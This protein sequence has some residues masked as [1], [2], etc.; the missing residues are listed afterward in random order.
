[1]W[2]QLRG[3]RLYDDTFE[4]SKTRTIDSFDKAQFYIN[5]EQEIL[6]NMVRIYKLLLDRYDVTKRDL[7]IYETLNNKYGYEPAREKQI[8]D[9]VEKLVDYTQTMFGEQMKE[10]YIHV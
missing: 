8:Q 2:T 1:V 7:K 9:Y 4:Y 10:I 6:N 3:V 5:K